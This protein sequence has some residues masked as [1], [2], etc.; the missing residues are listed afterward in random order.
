MLLKSICSQSI[1]LWDLQNSPIQ[2]KYKIVPNLESFTIFLPHLRMFPT[3]CFTMTQISL[4]LVEQPNSSTKGVET[5]ST[6]I[7]IF[8]L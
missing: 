7:V 4:Q 3:P 8:M 6:D 5:S 1:K 2:T